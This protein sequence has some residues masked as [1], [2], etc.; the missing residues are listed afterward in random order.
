MEDKKIESRE[1]LHLLLGKEECNAIN[2]LLSAVGSDERLFSIVR[3]QLQIDGCMEK[4]TTMIG[5][6]SEITHVNGWCKDKNCK[7][8]GSEVRY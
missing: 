8:N 1:F 7:T 6:I 2:Y 4:F 3:R 5:K